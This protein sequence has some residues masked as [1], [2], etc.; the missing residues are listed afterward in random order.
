MTQV[1]VDELVRHDQEIQALTAL[2]AAPGIGFSFKKCFNVVLT[3]ICVQASGRVTLSTSGGKIYAEVSGAFK[4]GGKGVSFKKKLPVVPKCVSL[5]IAIGS[6][7][8]CF[9]KLDLPSR[10]D[11]VMK[12]CVNAPII[13][14]Q[15]FTFF[16]KTIGLAS[17]ADF[18]VAG[19]DLAPLGI[20]PAMAQ[21]AQLVAF[22]IEED[23]DTADLPAAPSNGSGTAP[24][25]AEVPDHLPDFAMRETA[26]DRRF[27]MQGV[28][29][30]SRFTGT[31]KPLA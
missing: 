9:D 11:I 28:L 6:V 12:G 25:A 19:V 15:C 27:E 18:A 23:A 30:G 22:E 5:G 3:K 14:K 7:D 4:V 2:G 1:T 31:L 10:F 17:M 16:R 29:T 20:E 21:A 13:G 8:V 24:A 26:G